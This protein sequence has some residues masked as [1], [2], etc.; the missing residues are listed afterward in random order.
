MKLCIILQNISLFSV[1]YLQ[2][3]LTQQE[4]YSVCIE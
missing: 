1:L 4:S 3:V 2:Q